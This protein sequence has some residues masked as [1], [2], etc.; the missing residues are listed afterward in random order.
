VALVRTDA[1]EENSASIIRLERIGDVADSFHPDDGEDTF[2]RNVSSYK[3]H[4]ASHPKDDILHCQGRENLKS[5]VKWQISFLRK[6][7]S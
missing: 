2:F 1:S 3:S 4:M 6:L 5:D 7:L